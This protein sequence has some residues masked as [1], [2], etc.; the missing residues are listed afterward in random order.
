M[1]VDIDNLEH[2]LSTLTGFESLSNGDLT[3]PD[4]VYAKTVLKLNGVDFK[5][6]EGSESFM[7]S[8]KAGA[9]KVYE[10]IKNFLKAIRDFFFGSKGSKQTKTIDDAVKSTKSQLTFLTNVKPVEI[11]GLTQEAKERI[12][13][14]MVRIT[15]LMENKE[16]A[17]A[18][19]HYYK[20]KDTY[21][22][23]QHEALLKWFDVENVPGPKVSDSGFK[24]K[25]IKEIYEKI[26]K[27]ASEHKVFNDIKTP[28]TFIS[29][30]KTIAPLVTLQGLYQEMRNVATQGL[31]EVTKDLEYNNEIAKKYLND[32][33]EVFIKRGKEIEKLCK[34]MVQAS[35]N[36][37]SLIKHCDNQI[38]QIE[39]GISKLKKI[40]ED[41]KE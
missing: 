6:R 18:F 15:N 14:Q 9:Q 37:T 8:V 35:N 28:A 34:H 23:G 25:E 2:V 16:V 41:N 4:S 21:T 26:N 10:M 33:E 19:D 17:L 27:V 22:A 24:F 7:G 3:S 5:G 40:V 36:N 11:T 12:E 31:A 20:F 13:K 32:K 1:N 39:S 29:S 30:F 38:L